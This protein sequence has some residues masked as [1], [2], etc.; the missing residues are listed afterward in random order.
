MPASHER[1]ANR[2]LSGTEL[3]K[4]ILKDVEAILDK[5]GMLSNNLA[6]G[7]IAYEVRVS[8]HLDNAAYP[9]HISTIYSRPRSKSEVEKEPELA[10]IELG[11]L[12][13]PLTEDET[14][15]STEVQRQIASPNMARV[16]NGL[17][18]QIE[19]R[20]L[21]TGTV[22]IVEQKFKGDIPDPAEVGN[23][24]TASLTSEDQRA[25]WNKPRGGKK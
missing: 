9:E 10:A 3:K 8:M 25:K 5:D 21:D 1:V 23:V 24:V 6:Y 11:P 14:V 4:I 19:K 20:D 12:V 7:R 2:P 15:A 22:K 13:E 17:P 18:L 16:E